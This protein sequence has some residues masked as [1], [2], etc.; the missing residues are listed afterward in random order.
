LSLY[1]D[2]NFTAIFSINHA[3]FSACKTAVILSGYV[4][5]EAGRLWH[6]AM[7]AALFLE[8]THIICRFDVH[9]LVGCF[10]SAAINIAV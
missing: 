5:K 3:L 10:V 2:L 4:V 7:F 6:G 1:P 8:Q 9:M